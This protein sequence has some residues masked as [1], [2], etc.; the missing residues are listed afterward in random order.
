M[1]E[2]VGVAAIGSGVIRGLGSTGMGASKAARDAAFP[3]RALGREMLRGAGSSPMGVRFEAM[4]D[5]L[6]IP[7]AAAD[8]GEKYARETTELTGLN[9]GKQ[10]AISRDINSLSPQ[11]LSD[12]FRALEA[13]GAK[14]P[15]VA[16][17]ALNSIQREADLAD[18]SPFKSDDAAARLENE[19]RV[20]AEIVN[21]FAEGEARIDMPPTTREVASACGLMPPP[22]FPALT[23]ITFAVSPACRTRPTTDPDLR[24]GTLRPMTWAIMALRIASLTAGTW[25]SDEDVVT[26]PMPPRSPLSS[27][28][29]TGAGACR[30]I[31]TVSDVLSFGLSR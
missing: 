19:E 30:L 13:A 9:L 10:Q 27:N 24:L 23:T 6:G 3:E 31:R 18:N 25:P 29:S 22:F 21:I 20:S 15:A 7:R 26:E 2:A 28:T 12:G 14:I 5:A 8:A 4:G 1:A 17:G 16:R 11:Q